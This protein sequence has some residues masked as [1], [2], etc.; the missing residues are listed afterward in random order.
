MDND[1]KKPLNPIFFLIGK[2]LFTEQKSFPTVV[3]LEYHLVD[4]PLYLLILLWTSFSDPFRRCSWPCY[5]LANTFLMLE[6]GVRK[7]PWLTPIFLSHYTSHEPFFTYHTRLHFPDCAFP[8]NLFRLPFSPNL[9][10]E[11]GLV[12][13]GQDQNKPSHTLNPFSNASTGELPRFDI[14]L[15]FMKPSSSLLTDESL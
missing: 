5:C 3:N 2:C 11:I 7:P 13:Q 1:S 15:L 6:H 12:F 4:S 14:V 10:V 9:P 8:I